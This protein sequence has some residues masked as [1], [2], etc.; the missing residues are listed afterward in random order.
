MAA[1]RSR[2][3]GAVILISLFAGFARADDQSIF[4]K[5]F[6][7]GLVTEYDPTVINQNASPDLLNVDVDDG[8]IRKRGG[9]VTVSSSPLGGF[10]AQPTRFLWEYTLPSGDRNLIS[11]SSGTIFYS[12]NNGQDN[13]VLTSTLGF[14]SSSQLSAVNAFGKARLTDGTTNW[15][16]WD[17]TNVGVSTSAPHGKVSA[18]FGQRIWTGGVSG[19]AS[20]IYATNVNDPEDWVYSSTGSG[21][22]F[23]LPIRPT[24]GDGIKALFPYRDRVLC[25]ESRSLD[26]VVMNDDGLTYTVSPVSNLIGTDHPNSVRERDNDVVFLGPDGF[27]KYDFG[28]VG[29]T[30]KGVSGSLTRISDDSKPTR[31]T[32]QQ[33]DAQT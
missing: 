10:T 7:G 15:I 9:S 22:A 3:H 26:G 25:F 19:N 30:Y 27:Y 28:G 31:K 32:I 18:F 21:D 24:S 20:T 14:T 2:L 17:G 5:D 13:S 11:L 4:L 16:T 12:K 29:A 23:T 8:S 33:L 1:A 6:S